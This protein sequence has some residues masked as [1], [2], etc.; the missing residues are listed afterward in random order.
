MDDFSELNKVHKGVFNHTQEEIQICTAGPR[1]SMPPFLIV[2]LGICFV[3]N[4]SLLVDDCASDPDP[5][6]VH[7]DSE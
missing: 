7:D 5:H 1:N 2:G 6:P 3:L 4:L